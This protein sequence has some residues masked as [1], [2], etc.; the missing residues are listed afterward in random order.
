[1]K[2][3]STARSLCVPF[4]FAL[5]ALPAAVVQ[6]QEQTVLEEVIVTGVPAGGATKLEASVSVSSVGGDELI[7]FAPRSAAELFRA[8]PG[9]RA[10]SS[11]GGGNAN[12][13]VR[14]IPLATGGSKY[15]QIHE[16]GLPVLEYGDINFGNTDNWLRAD[17]TIARIESIRGGSASTFASNSP[18]GI[19]NMISKTGEEEGG[20]IGVSMGLDYDEFRTDF[21][22]GGSLTDTIHYHVG[23]FF[24]DG[25]GVRDTG[26][27]GENGGQLKAN[28]TKEFEDGYLRLYAKHLDDRVATYL[29]SPVLVEGG[30]SYGAVPGYDA[31]SQTLQS[32]QTNNFT[33]FDQFGNPVRRSLADGIESKV[34]AFGFEFEKSL[35]DQLT[36]RNKF[37][38]SDISGG[39]IAPFTD[40]FAGGTA[41]IADKGAELC[42]SASVAGVGL[43][44]SGGVTA[45][46]DGQPADGDQLAYTNLLFDTKIH[47][48]GLFVN[49]LSFSWEN[50]SGLAISG[51][52]YYSKQ[53][54][55]TSWNSW[56]TRMQTLDG[57]NSRNITYLANGAGIDE[58]GN[59]VDVVLADN[60]ALTQSFLAW[61]WDLEYTTF[62]PYINVGFDVG[63]RMRFDVSARHDEVEARGQRLDGC[64]G[65]NT[66]IDL[67]GD[68]SVGQFAV[69]GGV[70]TRLD[71]DALLENPGATS[72]GFIAGG[73]RVLNSSNAATTNVNYD[74]DNTSYSV[75][76]TFL[77][78]DASSV[79]AR[80]SD[81]GRAIADR[82][83]Q[84]GGSLR[85]DGSLTSTTDGFDNVQQLEIGYKHVGENWSAFATFFNTITE[86]TQAELT[87]GLTFVREYEANGIELEG[88]FNFSD[89]FVV[90]GNITWTDAEITDDATN[91][92]VVG[93]TPRRQADFIYTLIPE[94]R[95]AR[96]AT[97]LVLQGSTD[98]YVQDNNDLKQ[99]AYVLVNAFFNYD[100]T[101]D[102]TAYVNVNNLTDEFVITESE[103]GSAAVG[104]F[105]RARP[106]NG[107][108]AN[109]G[110]TYRF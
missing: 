87:S 32:Q 98:Y 34:S 77:L 51:G 13:T 69:D 59:A 33:T 104:S 66:P 31:S 55:K 3:Y 67:N 64:C 56:Q 94:Y 68:G 81:G 103:E 2:K 90:R 6:A 61:N 35:N 102:L 106:L 27:N 10:E 82:L 25:E 40:G 30:D 71:S 44:C 70:I 21:E 9:V 47:D 105:I 43:D 63:E 88:D 58:N 5:A 7:D 50:T 53:A 75:G 97:G 107:R 28:I 83:T 100:V 14:G 12:L 24:R 29:P 22:Y 92:A 45:L 38:Q 78:T 4:T 19:I 39:F 18:G 91:A 74:A 80:Y 101:Q 26:Y 1:M 41:S 48:L 57:S 72:A 79:F 76:G 89:S 46:I 108:S 110:I 11:G 60:G 86:E 15:M 62:A 42:A 54:I 84:V 99:E 37:R 49:D 23:G 20:S 52:L 73:V 8:L 16:D 95:N 96:L 36:V 17:W 93:N 65:G 109:I 85:P